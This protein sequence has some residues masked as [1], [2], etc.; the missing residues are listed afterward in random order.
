MPE[1]L[2]GQGSWCRHV[3]QSHGDRWGASIYTII[4][5]IYI[6]KIDTSYPKWTTYLVQMGGGV[7]E[8]GRIIHPGLPQEGAPKESKRPI[9]QRSYTSGV[10][11][12]GLHR[13]CRK[14]GL[15]FDVY[16]R[17]D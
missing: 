9:H 1:P 7:D 11:P 6:Y 12:K 10:D 4:Y 13:G 16:E 2:H 5:M 14:A 15:V 17:S 8:F 3:E